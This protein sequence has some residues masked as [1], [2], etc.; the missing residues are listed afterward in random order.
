MEVEVLVVES[1]VR[2]ARI[3]GVMVIGGCMV[4]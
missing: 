3:S 2:R 1:W 4:M